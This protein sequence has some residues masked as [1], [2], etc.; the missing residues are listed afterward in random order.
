MPNVQLLLDLLAH[1]LLPLALAR[2]QTRVVQRIAARVRRRGRAA[3]V[4]ADAREPALSLGRLAFRRDELRFG[5]AGGGRGETGVVAGGGV[6]RVC[7]G[8]G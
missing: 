3:R 7:G 6:P 4:V 5:R 2:A 1:L 8:G